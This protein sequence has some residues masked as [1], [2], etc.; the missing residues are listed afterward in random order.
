M[1]DGYLCWM[2]IFVAWISYSTGYISKLYFLNDRIRS[3]RSRSLPSRNQAKLPLLIDVT[4]L[5]R[6]S[7][8]LNVVYVS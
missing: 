4:F 3:I 1:L 6:F 2:D 7:L 5:C 8:P